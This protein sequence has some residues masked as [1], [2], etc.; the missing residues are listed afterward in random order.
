MVPGSEGTGPW[1]SFGLTSTNPLLHRHNRVGFCAFDADILVLIRGD[2]S[3]I[4]NNVKSGLIRGKLQVSPSVVNV[5]EPMGS[6]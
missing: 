3:V 4:S 2:V 1:P 5:E 6:S